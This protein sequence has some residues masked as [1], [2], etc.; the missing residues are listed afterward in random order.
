VCSGSDSLFLGSYDGTVRIVGPSW[1]VVRSFCAYDGGSG[2][3]GGAVNITH[4][5]QVEGTS[6]LVTVAVG[7]GCSGE[8]EVVGAL[9]WANGLV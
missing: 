4:M 6:L 9:G 5:W 2:A 1:K 8:W 3:A 7:L